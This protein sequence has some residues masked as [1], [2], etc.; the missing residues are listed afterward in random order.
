ML[1]DEFR[2]LGDRVLALGRTEGRGRASGVRVDSPL[3]TVFNF[4]GAKMSR[5]RAY[6]DHGEA[7]RAAGLEDG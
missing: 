4:S 1:Y 5:A 7:S 6:L 3:A 2:D